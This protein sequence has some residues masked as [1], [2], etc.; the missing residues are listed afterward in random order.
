MVDFYFAMAVAS[1]GMQ[2]RANKEAAMA[3]RQEAAYTAKMIDEQAKF[4]QLQAL[5]EHN[6]IMANLESFLDQNSS[7]TGIMGRDEGSDRSLKA[8]RSKAQKDTIVTAQRQNLQT[9]AELSKYSQQKNMT[10]MKANNESKAYNLAAY[11]SIVSGA[12]NASKIY[13]P[14]PPDTATK[15]TATYNTDYRYKGLD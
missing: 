10:I 13:S 9:L 15:S 14:S 2:Y 8:L 12:Y 1:A 7:L 4:R 6:S 11:S 5:Q 3:V